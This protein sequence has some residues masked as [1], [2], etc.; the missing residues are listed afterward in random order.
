V[1]DGGIRIA[2]CSYGSKGAGFKQFDLK[3]RLYIRP[4]SCWMN[5][6]PIN[7]RGVITCSCAL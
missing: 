1:S 7:A 3:V 6:R 5:W 2:S 4:T